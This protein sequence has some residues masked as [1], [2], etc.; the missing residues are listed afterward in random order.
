MKKAAPRKSQKPLSVTPAESAAREI[1]AKL[2]RQ[3][4]LHHDIK[5]LARTL[6]QTA[7][8]ATAA[9]LTTSIDIVKANGWSCIPKEEHERLYAAQARL[10]NVLRVE[11]GLTDAQLMAKLSEVPRG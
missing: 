9:L 10:E 8:A 2:A 11:Y 6:H 4:R 1:R 3:V 5:R 7:G